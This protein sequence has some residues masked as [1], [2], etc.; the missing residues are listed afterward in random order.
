MKGILTDVT[1]CIGCNRC[2]D[3]CVKENRLGKEIPYRW[4]NSDGLSGNRFTSVL[5][6]D[7]MNVRKQCRH[8]LKPA[9]ASACPVGAL[10]RT[11]QGA[12]VYDQS[13]CLGCRYCMMA[14]PFGIPRYTWERAVPYIRK[15]TMCS[16][17]R[18]SAG[19]QPACT[20][21]CPEKATIFGE[22]DELLQEAKNRIKENP[23]KYQSTIFGELTVGGTGVLYLSPISL[24]FLALGNQLDDRPLPER[25][26]LAMGAVPVAFVTM[27]ALMGGLYWIIERRSRLVGEKETGK[28]TD[29]KGE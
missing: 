12:V 1:K 23:H 9:C 16:A 14:C 2:V 4:Q 5:H 15:C 25:T 10:T 17:T 6:K 3:A 21:V 29:G 7:G 24:D 20:E 19:K 22:R 18:L 26:R 11:E 27:G 28:K 8:C 13:K